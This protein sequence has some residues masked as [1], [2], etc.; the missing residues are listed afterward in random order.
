MGKTSNAQGG[1]TLVEMIMVIV[2]TGIIG[3]IVAVFLRA[4]I[5]QYVD[6]ARRADMTDIADTAL[7]RV[8]RDLRRALPNSVRVRGATSGAGS[9][10][11]SEA[12]FLEF[13]PTTGGGRYRLEQD[14]TAPPCIGNVLDFTTATGVFD[15]I[16]P[17]PI[18]AAGDSI[19]VYNMTANPADPNPNAY[20]GGNSAACGTPC[21]AG[22]TITLAAA[23]LFPQDS[24][25]INPVTTLRE[26]CR[27]YVVSSPVTY[28]CAPVAGGAGGT[29]TRYWGYPIQSAQPAA[30]PIAGS[31]SALL[32]GNVS[33]C[34]FDY[35]NNVVAERSG[36]V[37]MNLS[38]SESGETVTLYSATHV[39]NVP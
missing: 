29:L 13:I 5:Q 26:G 7:R 19:V 18:F 39:N 4:P 6:V 21:S 37:T 8:G 35:S 22:S 24:C 30:V 1:F 36:L 38:I 28:V 3:S 34:R 15:V 31:T 12:C 17:M 25:Q 2:I 14:C 16:G 27:F 9:C 23:K 32:A 20:T 33:R 11:G 10:D